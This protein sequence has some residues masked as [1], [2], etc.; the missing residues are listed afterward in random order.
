MDEQKDCLIKYVNPS[1][2]L[3]DKAL[4]KANLPNHDL[5]EDINSLID[6]LATMPPAFTYMNKIATQFPDFSPGVKDN[7]EGK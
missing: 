7:Q 6:I 2:P 4:A 1:L 3:G 5:D